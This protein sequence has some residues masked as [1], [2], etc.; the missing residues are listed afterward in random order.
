VV[1]GQ[2]IGQH[3]E[4]QIQVVLVQVDQAILVIELQEDLVL[5]QANQEILE[6]L[7]LEILEDRVET[8]QVMLVEAVEEELVAQVL[9]IKHFQ[10]LLHIQDLVLL[11]VTEV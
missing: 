7:D 8:P 6:L 4:L 2:I 3:L 10:D 1:V 5:N 11:V 9:T